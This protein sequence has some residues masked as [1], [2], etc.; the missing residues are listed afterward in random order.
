MEIWEGT[1]E[2]KKVVSKNEFWD[3][4]KDIRVIMEIGMKVL[5][6]V[7]KVEDLDKQERA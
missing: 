3:R 7:F 6:I 5:M 1:L 4:I 2:D